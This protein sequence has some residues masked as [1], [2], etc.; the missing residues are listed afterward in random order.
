MLKQT[1]KNLTDKVLPGSKF[2]SDPTIAS[3]AL[4]DQIG[5]RTSILGDF[6]EKTSKTL[7]ALS[8]TNTL[9][10]EAAKE[11]SAE[12]VD[13]AFG[14]EVRKQNPNITEDKVEKE[15]LHILTKLHKLLDNHTREEFNNS[16][17]YNKY[18]TYFDEY[19]E[20]LDKSI[21][22]NST[23]NNSNTESKSYSSIRD[24][25]SDKILDKLLPEKT[26]VEI[27]ETKAEKE[28][29]SLTEKVNTVLE[30]IL[31]IPPENTTVENLTIN[32]EK[33]TVEIP[34]KTT[35]VTPEVTPE[36]TTVEI[37]EVTPEKTYSSIRDAASEKIL[38]KLLP[39]KNFNENNTNK[40]K[41]DLEA[42]PEKT[43]VDISN[44]ETKNKSSNIFSRIL[45]TF[46]K[47]TPEKSEGTSIFSKVL[48]SITPDTKDA[49][50]GP[51]ESS[52]EPVVAELKKTN[53]F[54]E[55]M[56]KIDKRNAAL[57]SENL[58]E[59]KKDKRD[60]KFDPS[61]K[62]INKPN[63][64]VTPEKSDT[65]VDKLKDLATGPGTGWLLGKAGRIL[66]TAAAVAAAPY[67]LVG[68]AGRAGYKAGEF[69]NDELLTNE[70]GSNKITDGIDSVKGWFGNSNED[71]IKDADKKAAQDLYDKRVAE[72]KLTDKSAEFFEKQGVKVDKSK[73]I[74]APPTPAANKTTATVA[75]EK[76]TSSV[77]NVA[78]ANDAS[79]TDKSTVPVPNKSAPSV[80]P[81]KNTSPADNITA[82]KSP[83]VAAV[84]ANVETKDATAA[85]PPAVQ[86]IVLNNNNSK[87][88]PDTGSKQMITSMNVRNSETTFERVQMQDFWPRTA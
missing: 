15:M 35:E 20:N 37:P 46:G 70:D 31:D 57:S 60:P 3:E 68:A 51:S 65:V 45:G 66:G 75:P 86:P 2:S 10:L 13:G 38:D 1:V 76:N 62:D 7:N 73:I 17:V 64:K 59:L 16:V 4:V 69:I 27:P 87:S 5:T 33:T 6:A 40:E 82:V 63:D 48:G 32:S 55:E 36:K 74:I 24:A 43:T 49:N 18:K 88:S 29:D 11:Y 44:K 19:K 12:N 39:G 9:R 81:T 72:G 14:Q 25:A 77:D 56:V 50:D 83:I 67:L 8:T 84:A 41:S 23:V 26:S 78:A 47:V 22:N 34:E 42:T 52:N 80:I 79:T 58:S 85:T 54:L 21:V 61:K 71:K 30:K 28:Q 53:H